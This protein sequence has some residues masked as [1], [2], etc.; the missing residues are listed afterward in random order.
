MQKIVPLP[1]HTSTA[2]KTTIAEMCIHRRITAVKSIVQLVMI[3]LE[4][5][6]DMLLTTRAE[7]QLIMNVG[8]ESMAIEITEMQI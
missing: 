3:I 1:R 5:I 2:W 6:I 8:V 4:A 7:N